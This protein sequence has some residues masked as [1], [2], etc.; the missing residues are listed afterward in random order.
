MVTTYKSPDSISIPRFDSLWE[1]N[2]Q[3]LTVFVLSVVGDLPI[4]DEQICITA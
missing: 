3:D 2:S 4:D 1:R